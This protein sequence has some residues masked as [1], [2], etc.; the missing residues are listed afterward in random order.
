MATERKI[1]ITA[2]GGGRRGPERLA[3]RH[4]DLGSPAHR[5]RGSTWGDELFLSIPVDATQEKNARD[6]VS[7]GELG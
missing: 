2:G 6:L 1:R 7:V 5:G 3:D 4:E